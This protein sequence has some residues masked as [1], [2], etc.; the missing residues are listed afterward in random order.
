M[1]VI[2]LILICSLSLQWKKTQDEGDE[3]RSLLVLL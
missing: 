2:L 1:T 3:D